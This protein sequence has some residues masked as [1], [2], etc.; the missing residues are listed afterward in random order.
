[1]SDARPFVDLDTPIPAFT[2][3]RWFLILAITGA[4]F[5]GTIVASTFPSSVAGYVSGAACWISL[6]VASLLMSAFVPVEIQDVHKRVSNNLLLIWFLLPFGKAGVAHVMAIGLYHPAKDDGY[7]GP[8]WFYWAEIV[9]QVGIGFALS[10]AYLRNPKALE[11]CNNV[12]VQT[13]WSAQVVA[14]VAFPATYWLLLRP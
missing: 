2:R 6:F 4:A 11:P 3:R 8:M 9:T 1:M 10:I 13:S 7:Q 12:Y 5:L 14:F